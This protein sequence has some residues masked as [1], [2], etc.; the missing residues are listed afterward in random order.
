MVFLVR[1][2]LPGVSKDD[3]EAGLFRT[4]SCV[5]FY[6]GMRWINSFWDEAKGEALCVYEAE[7]ADQLRDHAER[8]RVPCDEVIPVD[9]FGPEMFASAPN[10][11][12]SV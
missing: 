5:R 12:I 2:K 10:P 11:A 4:Y 1:R 6:E 7:N 8:S 3:I 9:S